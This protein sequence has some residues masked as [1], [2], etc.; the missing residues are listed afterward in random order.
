MKEDRLFL[1]VAVVAF[2]V[3]LVA[4]GLVY[5]SV[6]NTLEKITGYVSTGEVNLTV[7]TLAA[8]NFTTNQISWGSGRTNTDTNVANLTTYEVSNVTGGNW[9][10]TG[11]GGLRVENIGNV[12]VTLNLTGTKTAAQFIGGTGAVFKW[13]ITASESNSCLNE[14]GKAGILGL[15]LGTHH[16]VN[17]TV[18]ASIVCNVFRF[19]T[20]NDQVRIDFFL[21]VPSDSSTGL[22]GDVITATVYEQNPT[23]SG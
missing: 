17:V 7:E 16:N 9:S 3:S 15:D 20:G 5:Y 4:A 19:E 12:N 10:L 22:L 23:G 11:A 6:S 14:S 13:N 18:G 21:T 2:A 8:V 1:F